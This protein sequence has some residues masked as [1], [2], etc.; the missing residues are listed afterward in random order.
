[1]SCPVIFEHDPK[2]EA[3]IRGEASAKSPN[4]GRS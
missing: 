3:E 4:L 1:V 2:L